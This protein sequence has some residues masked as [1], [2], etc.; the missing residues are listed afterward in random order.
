MGAMCDSANTTKKIQYSELLLYIVFLPSNAT[1]S[2]YIIFFS[3]NLLRLAIDPNMGYGEHTFI[4]V[5]RIRSCFDQYCC[6]EA[7]D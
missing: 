6:F 7:I 3:F 5:T 2:Q 4:H 1:D